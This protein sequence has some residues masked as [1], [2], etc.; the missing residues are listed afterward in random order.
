MRRCYLIIFALA[1]AGQCLTELHL[2]PG[3]V[4]ANKAT[5]EESG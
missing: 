2:K 3:G 5:D 4:S 1:V